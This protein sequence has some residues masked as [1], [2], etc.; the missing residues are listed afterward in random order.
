MSE[1]EVIDLFAAASTGAA[2]AAV[3]SSHSQYLAQ[4]E[5]VGKWGNEKG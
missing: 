3:A 1:G 2:I 5:E 4:Q